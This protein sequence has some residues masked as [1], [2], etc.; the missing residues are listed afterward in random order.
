M[1]RRKETWREA[2]Q[3]YESECGGVMSEVRIAHEKGRQEMA[4]EI[5]NTFKEYEQDWS[6]NTRIIGQR[7]MIPYEHYSKIKKKYLGEENGN[8]K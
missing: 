3:S 6:H 5:F 1:M 7:L 8:N 4:T 2:L